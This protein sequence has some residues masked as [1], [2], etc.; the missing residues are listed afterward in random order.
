MV[1]PS[2]LPT[3][4]SREGP[5]TISATTIRISSSVGPNP[6]TSTSL[7]RRRVSFDTNT[8]RRKLVPLVSNVTVQAMVVVYN[9]RETEVRM[10]LL[11]V[12]ESNRWKEAASEVLEGRGSSV[13]GISRQVRD[14]M[15]APFCYYLGTLLASRG[16]IEGAMTWLE[17]GMAVE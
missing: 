2:I 13:D 7:R 12:E 8:N 14:D 5:K 15:R 10:Y 17:A 1:S 11:S 4:G 9:G 16:N 6:N 3:L